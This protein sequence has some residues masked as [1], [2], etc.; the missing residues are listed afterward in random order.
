MNIAY[1]PP[2]LLSRRKLTPLFA[3]LVPRLSEF[4]AFQYLFG[5]HSPNLYFRAPHSHHEIRQQALWAPQDVLFDAGANSLVC[6]L[7]GRL[8]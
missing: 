4:V 8:P 1:L 6:E 5:A 3:G 7:M 2:S